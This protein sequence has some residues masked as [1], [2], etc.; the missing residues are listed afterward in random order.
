MKT[1]R[2][3][4]LA[5]LAAVMVAGCAEL[6]ESGSGIGIHPGDWS[7]PGSPNNHAAAL[8]DEGLPNS[9][10]HCGSC[11]GAD[12][13]KPDDECFVCHASGADFGHPESG[14]VGS[15]GEDFHGQAV[16]DMAG[17]D[18]CA[19]CHAWEA[20][21][22]LDFDLGGWAQV[23]CNACHEG[24]RSGHPGIGEWFNPSSPQFHGVA[25]AGAGIVDCAQCHGE[26]YLG[27]WAGVSCNTCHPSAADI[28]PAGWIG[29]SSTPDTHGYLILASNGLSRDDCEACHGQDLEGGWS[30]QDCR[31]CHNDFYPPPRF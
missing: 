22:D 28:H 9:A 4:V 3:I 27:G 6:D 23:A 20:S 31:P 30:G 26:D 29:A 18:G 10:E 5:F 14:F 24:G 2:T 16:I 25:A 7:T 13:G 15:S 17:T 12:Y 1:T 8:A 11:H 21:G 19:A